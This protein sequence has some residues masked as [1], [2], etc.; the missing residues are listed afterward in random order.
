MNRK[1]LNDVRKLMSRRGF[2]LQDR[3]LNDKLSKTSSY[4]KYPGAN[5]ALSLSDKEINNKFKSK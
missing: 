4:K 5:L 1:L 2:L 3:I